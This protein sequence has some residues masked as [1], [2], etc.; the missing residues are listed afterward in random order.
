MPP[1]VRE[2]YRAL[3]NL[4]PRPYFI[5]ARALACVLGWRYARAEAALALLHQKRWAGCDR[6]EGR[7]VW[8]ATP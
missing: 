7:D 4:R 8:T 1:D 3:L 2:C 5:T 6:R